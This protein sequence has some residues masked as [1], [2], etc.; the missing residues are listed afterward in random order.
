M[1]P[2][3]SVDDAKKYL[4]K[5]SDVIYLSWV[6]NGRLTKYHN[7][8]KY[9][10]IQMVGVVG[11]N[12]YESEQAKL[13]FVGYNNID[14]S[15]IFFLKGGLDFAKLPF[16]SRSY[17]HSM[18]KRLKDC[19]LKNGSSTTQQYENVSLCEKGGNYISKNNL[20]DLIYLYNKYNYI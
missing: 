15:S 12:N 7:A 10:N 6:K 2:M 18:G 4:P 3:F 13:T 19:I 16:V 9:F 11:L 14:T 1:L 20:N 17:I 5:G 8:K